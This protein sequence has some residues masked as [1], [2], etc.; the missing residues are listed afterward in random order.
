[1]K[2]KLQ[3]DG[4]EYFVEAAADGTLTID[5]ETF[6]SKTGTTTADR[7]TVQ[8]GE[9]NYEIRVV[10]STEEVG[11]FTLEVAG[12]RVP[13]TVSDL[14]R[15]TPQT[16]GAPSAARVTAGPGASAEGARRGRAGPRSERPRDGGHQGRP[17]RAGAREDRRRVRQ[18]R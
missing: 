5:G 15:E 13:L 2:F 1:M 14:V 8:V 12:E 9:K 10:E 11:C 6:E 16:A 3:V 18:T 17:L 7:R 4:N